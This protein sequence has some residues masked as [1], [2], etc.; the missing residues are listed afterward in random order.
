MFFTVSVNVFYFDNALFFAVCFSVLL[1]IGHKSDFIV[2]RRVFTFYQI[3]YVLSSYFK[4]A[5]FVLKQHK[6]IMLAD[7]S[8]IFKT[9][10]LF[11]Y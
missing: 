10:K 5:C 2:K 8:L 7:L 1:S 3:L 9:T 4:Y 11:L 6:N